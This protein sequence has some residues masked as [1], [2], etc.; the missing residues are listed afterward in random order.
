MND[1]FKNAEHAIITNIAQLFKESDL[2]Y[3][4]KAYSR[5]LFLIIVALEEIGRLILINEEEFAPTNH[6]TKFQRAIEWN[7]KLIPST[8][9]TKD[10]VESIIS[11]HNKVIKEYQVSFKKNPPKEVQ[12]ISL[13]TLS[14]QQIRKKIKDSYFEVAKVIISLRHLFLYTDIYI[15]DDHIVGNFL[16]IFATDIDAHPFQDFYR[17]IV[18]EFLMIASSH[19]QKDRDG[20]MKD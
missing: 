19:L 3:Q 17:E 12:L 2:L 9:L 15:E 4:H 6:L 20:N 13:E 1:D 10:F 16:S 7:L 18:K 14:E 8:A 11:T 5:S